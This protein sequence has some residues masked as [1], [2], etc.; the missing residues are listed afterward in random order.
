MAYINGK[1]RQGLHLEPPQG[2]LNDPN[3]LCYFNGYYHVYFQYAP[4]NADGSGKKCWGHYRSPDMLKWEF[5]GTVLFPDTPDDKD[6]VYSGSAVVCGDILHIFYTGNVKEDGDHDYIT[7]GRGA[8]IIHVTSADGVT[9]SAKK[10][11]LRN[12]DY[13]DFCSCHVRD[14]KVWLENG[15]WRMVLGARTLDNKG[16]VLFY[17]SRD[18]ENWRYDG[19][20]STLE[21]GYMW[22]CPDL[23][24]F[25]GHGYLSV[26]PQGLE[27]GEMKYQNVYQSGYFRCENELKN[28]TEWDMGFDFYAPQTFTAPDGRRILI[29][30]LGIGDIPYSNPTVPLGYQHC[31]T[32]PR[33]ITV[34]S[35]GSLLQNPI[36]ELLSLRGEKMS[37]SDG[38]RVETLLPFDLTAEVIGSFEITLCGAL[39]MSWDGNIFELRFTNEKFGGGRTV[40]KVALGKCSN[41]R[42][43]ADKSSVEIYL[44]D[45]KTV[46]SSRMYPESDK[47]GLTV[48]GLNAELFTL[49]EMEVS[50]LGE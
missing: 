5:T 11:V 21:F 14:T 42:I 34:D 48:K 23:L 35:D 12:S 31:L 37:I 7:S 28:F 40:R 13:P 27:H 17:S 45:G 20:V 25:D 46:L 32:V 3:G 38:E 4:D 2:W 44:D 10:T 9:M 29:G 43:I 8:N 39:T 16:C 49:K 1:W 19:T 15:V 26:S 47:V 22:E 18:L 50:Y 30:W 24:D 33:K 36:R 41:I 6:G